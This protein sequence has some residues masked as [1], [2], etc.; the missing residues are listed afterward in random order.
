MK[1]SLTPERMDDP[2]VPESTMRTFHR[3]LDRVH[4]LMG[5]AKTIIRQLQRGGRPV[6]SV[7]DIGCGHGGLLAKIRDSLGVAVTGIDLRAPKRD[8]YGVSIVEADASCYPPP[9]DEAGVSV[10]VMLNLADK[11]IVGLIRSVGR[12]CGR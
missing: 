5:N 10:Y 2:D 12:L 7:L 11:E 3:D 6:R 4:A 1:R 9:K 8:P